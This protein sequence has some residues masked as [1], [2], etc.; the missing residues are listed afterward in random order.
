[1]WLVFQ[2]LRKA[3]HF[4]ASPFIRPIK[5]IDSTLPYLKISDAVSASF[6][7]F[8]RHASFF[9]QNS[10]FSA[11]FHWIIVMWCPFFP[12]FWKLH[13]PENSPSFLKF[14]STKN[15]T[16]RTEKKCYVN[17]NNGWVEQSKQNN[18]NH[19]GTKIVLRKVLIHS[20]ISS[21]CY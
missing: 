21:D 20:W 11:S 17:K 6:S 14:L 4:L 9:V 3:I 19:V 2:Q 8:A 12:L 5:Q 15:N 1:M 18:N 16:L 7:T 10:I 13:K